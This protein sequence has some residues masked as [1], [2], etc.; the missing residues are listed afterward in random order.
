MIAPT[1]EITD[2]RGSTWKIS[3]TPLRATVAALGLIEVWYPCLTDAE[4]FGGYGA[5]P[6]PVFTEWF[7]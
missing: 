5:I 4:G 6:L 3:M 1:I 2:F 7:E